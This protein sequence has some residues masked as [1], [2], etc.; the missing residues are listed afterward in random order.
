LWTRITPNQASRML[1]NKNQFQD[2]PVERTKFERDETEKERI[3]APEGSGDRAI[4]AFSAGNLYNLTNQNGVTKPLTEDPRVEPFTMDKYVPEHF[5]TARH[6]VPDFWTYDGAQP[7]LGA[8][9]KTAT[10]RYQLLPHKQLTEQQFMDPQRFGSKKGW[11]FNQFTEGP[12]GKPERTPTHTDDGFTDNLKHNR[13]FPVPRSEEKQ[14][15]AARLFPAID[16]ENNSR[17]I[18]V[19]G[20]N[21][22]SGGMAGGYHE[23]NPSRLA[24]LPIPAKKFNW[25]GT[26]LVGTGRRDVGVGAGAG[27]FRAGYNSNYPYRPN[28]PTRR[29][30]GLSRNPAMS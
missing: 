24:K 25:T 9:G 29:A 3:G 27:G 13:W 21:S 28:F 6:A 16:I 30:T 19:T 18:G 7:T 5:R 22:G 8:Q 23:I 4:A 26:E 12:V 10:S 11:G 20:P 15:T 2:L 17:G 14:H 1:A